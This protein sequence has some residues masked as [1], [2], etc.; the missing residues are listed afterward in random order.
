MD[1][2]NILD[3]QEFPSAGVYTVVAAIENCTPLDL[4]PLAEVIDPDALDALL[5]EDTRTDEVSFKYCGY[6]VTVTSDE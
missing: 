4:P 6:T 5:T 1:Q 3:K 2:K